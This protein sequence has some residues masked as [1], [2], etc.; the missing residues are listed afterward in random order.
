MLVWSGRSGGV[1]ARLVQ[2]Q[3]ESEPLCRQGKHLV[4]I[5][6]LTGHRRRKLS[7]CFAVTGLRSVRSQ[8]ERSH[9]FRG[10]RAVAQCVPP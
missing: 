2:E 10:V 8:A 5:F 4:L 3:Q 7:S 1:P 6:A 9:R